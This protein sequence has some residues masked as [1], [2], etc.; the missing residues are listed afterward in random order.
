M[1]FSIRIDSTEPDDKAI[2]DTDTRQFTA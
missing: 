1:T 2:Q